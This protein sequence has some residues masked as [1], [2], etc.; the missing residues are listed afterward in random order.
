[1]E[2]VKIF[3]FFNLQTDKHVYQTAVQWNESIENDSIS[4]DNGLAGVCLL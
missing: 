2:K 1:M 3:Y 4:F